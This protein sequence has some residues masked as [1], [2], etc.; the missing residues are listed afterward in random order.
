MQSAVCGESRAF[1]S[2]PTAE[3]AYL[4]TGVGGLVFHR[5]RWLSFQSAPTARGRALFCIPG[6]IGNGHQLAPDAVPHG[7]RRADRPAGR[8]PHGAEIAAGSVRAAT[9]PAAPAPC[10]R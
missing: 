6:F 2:H 1:S 4:S 7:T 3:V 5:R 10:P 9:A 8:L